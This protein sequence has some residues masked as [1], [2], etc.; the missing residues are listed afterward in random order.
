[1]S[2]KDGAIS[3]HILIK[4]LWKIYESQ[5]SAIDKWIHVAT[6][7]TEKN[8]IFVDLI[9]KLKKEPLEKLDYDMTTK[10]LFAKIDVEKNHLTLIHYLVIVLHNIIYDLA[11]QEGNYF[12]SLHGQE[13][14]I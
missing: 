11:S 7:I 5:D 2:L 1:M 12:F 10:D 8:N 3:F 13:E 14:M 4:D 9:K 6:Q